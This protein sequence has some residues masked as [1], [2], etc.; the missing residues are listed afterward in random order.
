MYPVWIT[1][2]IS[3]PNDP[4]LVNQYTSVIMCD[5]AFM[6]YKVVNIE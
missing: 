4:R 1:V 2:S 6:N 5:I 3:G